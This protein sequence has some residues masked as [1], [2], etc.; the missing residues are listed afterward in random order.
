MTDDILA[1]P[2]TGLVQDRFRAGIVLAWP[3]RERLA[4]GVQTPAGQSAGRFR[5][6]FFGVM[7]FTEREQF[8]ELAGEVFVGVTAAAL[9]L[10]EPDQHGGILGCGFEKAWPSCRAEFAEGLVLAPH[11]V[12]VA[13]FFHT[14]GEMAVPEEGEF[15][16]QRLGAEGHSL[17]PPLAETEQPVLLEATFLALKFLPFFRG[18][19]AVG[20]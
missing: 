12:S 3:E 7:A 18:G 9:R 13:D 15:F 16:L 19:L 8:E 6:V 20:A 11:E 10:V 14:G 4:A 1:F 17:E 5:D 2:G